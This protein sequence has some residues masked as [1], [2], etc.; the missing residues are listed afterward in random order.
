VRTLGAVAGLGELIAAQVPAGARVLAVGPRAEEVAAAYGDGAVCVT[1]AAAENGALPAGS[2]DIVVSTDVLGLADDPQAMLARLRDAAGDDGTLLVFEPDGAE[3]LR[4]PA[5]LAA[6]RRRHFT[7]GTLEAELARAGLVLT[8]WA[9]RGGEALVARAVAGG[10]ALLVH[11]LRAQVAALEG[12]AV[13]AE[14]LA[15]DNAALEARVR[16]LEA[17]ETELRERL[18]ATH[19]LLADRDADV[20]RLV[21]SDRELRQ[22]KETVVFRAGWRYWHVKARARRVAGKVRRQFHG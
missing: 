17:R 14:R 13:R 5:R 1:L 11:D 12:Q 15:E 4:D 21:E 2:Y 9:G 8:G 18:L 6:D 20:V 10:E 22:V 3:T 16:A 19:E 7:A